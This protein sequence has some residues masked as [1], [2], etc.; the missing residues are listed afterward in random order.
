MKEPITQKFA[1]HIRALRK[2]RGLTQEKLGAL[3]RISLKY[4]QRIEGKCPPD[5][6]IEYLEKLSK[7]FGMPLW[8]LLKFE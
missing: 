1:K 6:G 8:E 5:I 4:I 7:G 3:S 2:E